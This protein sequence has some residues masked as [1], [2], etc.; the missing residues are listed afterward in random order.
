MKTI[1][2]ETH[3]SWIL[4]LDFNQK[5]EYDGSTRL[6]IN[7]VHNKNV[8][9][10]TDA[11]KF[12]SLAESHTPEEQKQFKNNYHHRE[13]IR[14]HEDKNVLFYNMQNRLAEIAEKYGPYIR[15]L[16]I[17]SDPVD[18]QNEDFHNW[19]L[20]FLKK[21]KNLKVFRVSNNQDQYQRDFWE[22]IFA[23]VNLSNVHTLEI[24]NKKGVLPTS[25]IESIPEGIK[26]LSICVTEFNEKQNKS[27]AL[28]LNNC[29]SLNLV[30]VLQYNETKLDKV[31]YRDC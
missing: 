13:N 28:K 18:R 6:V 15:H 2:F 1:Y 11:P 22:K 31:G 30:R 4:Y 3:E 12:I 24:N 14:T 17:N 19:D 21:F 27:L 10:S 9:N 25:A 26:N 20:D 16:E 7:F 29:P 5:L 8:L 23:N